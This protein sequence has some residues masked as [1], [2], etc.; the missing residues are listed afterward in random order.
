MRMDEDPT[1]RRYRAQRDRLYRRL[2]DNRTQTNALLEALQQRMPAPA[3]AARLDGLERE[4][5]SL[6][7]DYLKQTT[8]VTE[9]ILQLE[10]QNRRPKMTTK[11]PK[12]PRSQAK[13]EEL[14][15]ELTTNL[16]LERVDDAI[17]EL[18][19]FLSD[20]GFFAANATTGRKRKLRTLQNALTE[21]LT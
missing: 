3:D 20:T 18:L 21:A 15:Q 10:E 5:A 2:T 8:T 12:A 7:Q 13:I 16:R 11:R 6:L 9:Y 17:K 14:S 19:N 1:L 4:H